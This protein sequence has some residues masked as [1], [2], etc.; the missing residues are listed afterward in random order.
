MYRAKIG[1]MGGYGAYAGLHFYERVLEEFKTGREI[2]YPHIIMDND[3]T[4]P[5]R[6]RALLYGEA[7]E[8]VVFD[9][10]SSAKRLIGAG[11]D[12]IIMCC[13]TAH[14]FLPDVYRTCPELK[15]E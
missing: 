12:Y 15:K 6:T 4:M 8:E 13:G 5:S 11:A 9:I 10:A 2:D 3:F 7:Y 14:A 1:I